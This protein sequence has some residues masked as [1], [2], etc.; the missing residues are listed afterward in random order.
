MASSFLDALKLVLDV[1]G[2][3]AVGL[4]VLFLIRRTGT[5]RARSPVKLPP[6]TDAGVDEGF[7]RLVKQ[8]EMAFGTVSNALRQEHRMLQALLRHPAIG[9]DWG[10][11]PPQV[12]PS[13]PVSPKRPPQAARQPDTYAE[14]LRLAEGGLNVQ[15]IEQSL[16]IPRGEIELALKFKRR[17]VAAESP[18]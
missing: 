8:T 9:R 3:F 12:Q 7:L 14:A 15:E 16:K 11:A 17:L 5:P 4:G 18:V 10:T 2:I 1:T 13:A 6:P